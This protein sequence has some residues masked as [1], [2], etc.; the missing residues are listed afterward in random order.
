MKDFI[1]DQLPDNTTKDLDMQYSNLINTKTLVDNMT[2][3]VNSLS[4][5]IQ[6]R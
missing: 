4:Q 2:E 3:K 6:K 1:R 5:K